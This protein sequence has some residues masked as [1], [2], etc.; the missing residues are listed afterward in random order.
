MRLIGL[1]VVLT[2]A[3]LAPLAVWWMPGI[4]QQITVSQAKSSWARRNRRG[5]ATEDH[6]GTEP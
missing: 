6:Y 2:L 3:L 4:S 1:A 5:H